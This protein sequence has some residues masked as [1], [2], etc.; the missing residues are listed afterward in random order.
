M[1]GTHFRSLAASLLAICLS[2][3]VL[4]AETVQS[5]RY[6][7]S[8]FHLY[9]GDYF[10]SLTELMVGQEQQTLGPHSENAELLRGGI[11][12]SYG[13]DDEAERVFAALLSEPRDGVDAGRAWF[14]LAKLAWQRG[15][16]ERAQNA[17]DNAGDISTPALAEEANY[18]RALLALRRGDRDAALAL[19]STLPE[20]SGWRYYFHY[21]LGASL[22]AAGEFA[23]AAAQFR[24]LE[25]AEASPELKSLR[26]RALTASGY[27]L[28][29]TSDF[30][31]A[32]EDFV[33]VRLESPVSERALL[34]YGWAAMEASDP[35]AA[36]SP[37]QVLS[38]RPAVSQSVRESLLAIPYAYEQLGRD[39]LALAHYREAADTL[40]GEL[41][42]V[43]RAIALF[44]GD[45]LE[46]LL[47][48][49]TGASD[50]WLFGD[51]ILP[52]SDEAPYLRHLIA[53]HRFQASMK[54]MRDLQRIRSHLHHSLAKLDVLR[55]ADSEHQA[56]W[57]QLIDGGGR[58][59]LARQQQ[60][61]N[62]QAQAL[63]Q[64]LAV[65][66]QHGNGRDFADPDRLAQW[67]RVER[68]ADLA[69]QID[70]PENQ[71]DL[72][73][74]YRGLLI[75]DD[76]EQFPDR[77]WSAQRELAELQRALAESSTRLAR[78]DAAI[79]D[80]RESN[81]APRIA[82]LTDRVGARQIDVERALLL[83][84][85]DLRRVAIAELEQQSL[86]L[87]RSLGQ[88]RLAVARLYDRG[89]AGVLQ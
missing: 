70:A 61:L 82:A 46:S 35:M 18:L 74:V 48:L 51:D 67:K 73:R 53:S 2:A 77:L 9:Q 89:S 32:R 16:R 55:G 64:R 6:G 20:E 27:A 36:L 85:S 24:R 86:A 63:R 54:E 66:E 1:A 4:S 83:S 56:N 65:A 15:D 22:A 88:S 12:L 76:N 25:D 40:Q 62:D 28:M 60:E 29:A 78:L 58:E 31:G 49:D 37:W 69:E 38:R 59:R 80:R 45:S 87:S 50:E 42:S 5:L 72:L 13:M 19:V 75:W 23:A 71:R 10:N 26:D 30:P 41:D 21:N 34:G 84:G 57:K 3:P 17:L 8:L 47:Q 7:V 14:Y 68:A 11:A 81:Y 52:I 79:A 33:R 44:R 43:S 39:G